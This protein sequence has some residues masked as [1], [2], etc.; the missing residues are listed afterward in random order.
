[1][2]TCNNVSAP[3][4]PQQPGAR[5]SDSPAAGGELGKRV[6]TEAPSTENKGA[7]KS[8]SDGESPQDVLVGSSAGAGDRAGGR[9][10]DDAV[11][12]P[13]TPEERRQFESYL[14]KPNVFCGYHTSVLNKT[15]EIISR[16]E[17]LYH[18]VTAMHTLEDCFAN[19]ELLETFTKLEE[20]V[21][22]LYKH[23][24]FAS[25]CSLEKFWHTEEY[26]LL[27]NN[28][29]RGNSQI[30]NQGQRDRLTS[31][32]VHAHCNAQCLLFLW[33]LMEQSHVDSSG[34]RILVVDVN[35]EPI[36]D[37][38]FRTKFEQLLLKICWSTGELFV[39]PTS[40]ND[41]AKVLGGCLKCLKAQATVKFMAHAMKFNQA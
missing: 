31:E 34:S 15:T 6:Q 26:T 39:F 5:T 11:V 19:V 33:H 7:K 28:I 8:K 29:K 24:H 38:N 41:M 2:F 9:A 13:F 4:T 35:G 18:T 27:R 30:T 25:E 14:T 12:D 16:L 37:Q 23:L 3:A 10:D 32:H 20:Q 22:R 36:E 40:T 1:M 21:G 17:E